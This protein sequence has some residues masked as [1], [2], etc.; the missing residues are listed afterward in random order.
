[1]SG[2][3]QELIDMMHDTVTIEPA[4]G[5]DRYG[6]IVLGAP[7]S[8]RCVV[9]RQNKAV[10]DEAGRE[11]TSTV[12]VIFADPTL[13]LSTDDRLTIPGTDGHP[14]IIQVLSAKDEDGDP[15][16]LEIRA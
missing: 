10:R 12:Q 3:D 14:A 8:P 1:M 4:T 5:R 13:T 2:L 9:F 15:Y 7:I 11:T 6:A 16:H